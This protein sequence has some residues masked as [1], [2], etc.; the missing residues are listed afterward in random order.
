MTRSQFS[1]FTFQSGS[2]AAHCR[3]ATAVPESSPKLLAVP[4]WCLTGGLGKSC[5][6]Q[7]FPS[8]H[9]AARWRS[10]STPIS[11]S[12]HSA[13]SGSDS[14][15]LK[16]FSTFLFAAALKQLGGAG[17]LE[18]AGVAVVVTPAG[19]VRITQPLAYIHTSGCF[20]LS[21][22]PLNSNINVSSRPPNIISN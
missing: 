21:S 11:S 16:S 12:T 19:C 10:R 13:D 7:T 18:T 17:R 1:Q 2:E 8:S 20:T 6:F 9:T 5:F 15:R 22:S 3:E 14:R 4:C